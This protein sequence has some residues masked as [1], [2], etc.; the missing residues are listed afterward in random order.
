MVSA[1]P[2]YAL[3]SSAF[4]FAG[5][6]IAGIAVHAYQQTAKASMAFLAVGFA[7]LTAATVSTAISV[8]YT[9]YDSIT[10]VLTVH[11]GL[12]VVGLLLIVY[13]LAVHR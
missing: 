9:G 10:G 13:S 2:L 5:L 12:S 4:T 11:A 1:E 3:F 7:F 6:A 8:F